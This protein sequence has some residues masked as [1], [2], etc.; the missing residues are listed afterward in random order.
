MAMDFVNDSYLTDS[1]SADY[2][3]G[4]SAC[5]MTCWVKA[6]ATGSDRGWHQAINPDGT[7]TYLSMRHDAVGVVSGNNNCFKGGFNLTSG[8]HNRE[9]A[10]NSQST[11]WQCLT[12]RWSSGNIMQYYI[13]GVEDTTSDGITGDGVGT[14]T[15]TH[16]P[17][18]VG[19]GTKYVDTSDGWNGLLEDF[20]VYNR[21]L[22][23]AEIQTICV[24]KGNDRIFNGLLIRFCFMEY[25]PGTSVATT[26]DLVKDWGNTGHLDL[27]RS[28]G[29]APTWA[30][31]YLRLGGRRR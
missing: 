27:T 31:S 23:E 19:R 3:D 4:L 2:L 5:T 1:N 24:L 20:R 18:N 17:L 8:Q 11:D 25:S 16:Q 26:S 9:T 10:E 21:S 30:E 28:G 12:V 15:G 22:S 13:D 14:F 6:D 7:D 29:S